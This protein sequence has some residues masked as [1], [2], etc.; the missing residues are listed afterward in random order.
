[1]K[2]IDILSL[3]DNSTQVSVD[4]A[5]RDGEEE[6]NIYYGIVGDMPLGTAKG[7]DVKQMHA[8][9]FQIRGWKTT[10]TISGLTIIVERDE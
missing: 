9:C 7:F 3:V 4:E 8:T 6:N 1:M 2:L 10:T 5:T